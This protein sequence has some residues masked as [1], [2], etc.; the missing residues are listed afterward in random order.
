[1][2]KKE[3]EAKPCQTSSLP[4]GSNAQDGSSNEDQDDNASTS[5]D[6]GS[7]RSTVYTASSSKWT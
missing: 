3:I 5:D 2:E 4:S 7:Q 1:M 6:S